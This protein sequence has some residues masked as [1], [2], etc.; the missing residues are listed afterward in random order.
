VERNRRAHVFIGSANATRAAWSGNVAVLV[1]LV[2]GASKLGVDTF[3]DDDAPFAALLEPYATTGGASPDPQEEALRALQD[4]LRDL[5]EAR[6]TATITRGIIVG[7]CKVADR[8]GRHRTHPGDLI[9][10][11][12]GSTHRPTR[13]CNSAVADHLKCKCL[14]CP[15]D[16]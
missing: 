12:N 10:K 13:L 3:L 4:L 2:G 6:F 11:P 9:S 7:T 5:A 1:E 15:Q 16:A 8:R 14:P